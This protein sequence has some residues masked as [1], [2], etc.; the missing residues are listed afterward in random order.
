MSLKAKKVLA[1]KLYAKAL[2]TGEK[3]TGEV[4]L[5]AATQLIEND[6]TGYFHA[7][8][9]MNKLPVT[10]DEFIES[11]EF[12]GDV[13]TVWDTLRDDLRAYNPDVMTGLAP[14]FECVDGGATS[15]G[16]THKAMITQMYQLY[17]L[18]CFDDPVRL[19]P[20]LS[21]GTPIVMLFQSVQDRIT[22]RVIYQP[23]RKWFLSIPYV[24]RWVVH[25]KN[26]E[27][28]L[29]LDI[30]SGGIEV[31]PALANVTDIVGQAIIGGIL[32]EVNQMSIVEKSKQIAGPRGLGGHYDQAEMVHGELTRR[33]LGRFATKG[34]SVG[35]LSVLSS[36]RYKGD[37]LD[38]RQ[39][40]I[41]ANDEPNVIMRR[42]AQYEVQPDV[43]NDPDRFKVLVG[44]TDFS[45]MILPD[46]AKEGV[47]YM[48]GARILEVPE[49]YRPLFQ[50]DPEGALRDVCGIATDV[51]APY[52][53]K[54]HK[55]AE[56]FARA[57]K[58]GLV[59]FVHN[60]N[61][62]TSVDGMP[63][64]IPEA[65]PEDLTAERFIHIDLSRTG[66]RTGLA[67][68]KVVGSEAVTT[69]EGIVEIMPHIH[70]ELAV[71]IEPTP[72][73]PI[74]ISE[75]RRWVLALKNIYGFNIKRVT[76]DHVDSHESIMIFRASGISSDEVSIDRDTDPYD[77][78]RA[79]LYDDRIEIV[80]NDILKGELAN[81][82]ENKE[83]EK[84][85]HPPKGCFSGETRVAL[86]DGTCPTFEELTERY[87]PDDIFY[88]YSM[89]PEGVR[90]APARNPR[91][92]KQATELVE[93]QLDNF[94]VVRCTPDHLFMTLDGEWVQAGN[95]T[96]DISIMPLYRTRAH[97]GGWAGYERVWC[98]VREKRLLTHQLS[99]GCGGVTG[100]HVHHKDEV[101]HNNDPRNLEVMTHEEHTRKHSEE[102]WADKEDKM[103][104]G[105]K[106]YREDKDAQKQHA[107][108]MKKLWE[109]GSFRPRAKE[110]AIE[111][112]TSK[113]KARG[114][115]D[116]HYQRAKRAGKLP[117]RTS[118]AK[119]HRVLSVRWVTT[120]E[121]VYDL[122]VPDTENFA[123]ASGVF[124]HNSKDV[125]DAVAGCVYAATVSRKQR[126]KQ[127]VTTTKVANKINSS[128]RRRR[129]TRR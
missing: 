65:L 106:R 97:S 28:T 40:N 93:V 90:I 80:E 13:L 74:D 116:L 56:A 83:K 30:G 88:V 68:C 50:N 87:G 126:A 7:I 125:A 114:L 9:Q 34:V 51:I 102:R 77:T 25:D 113:S 128:T 96:P 42:R 57:M 111:G 11:P 46:N 82:E 123:L 27:S 5:N 23:F 55:I 73:E 103:R 19:F 3:R 16:K 98:P 119:N 8:G 85:D 39:A 108:R 47:D 75:I 60:Q 44:D 76:Y 86:A 32:D 37:F 79:A 12:L 49:R 104:A 45:T 78:L 43:V 15:T 112:C 61:V 84:I 18:T 4:F 29:R 70:V 52:I 54:R 20:N 105:H 22:R 110:C 101:K 129:A 24:K 10:I 2:A 118:K 120:D 64:V 36:T 63:A 122:T 62:L 26:R 121:P 107:E 71:S 31:A 17:L 69:S 95:L 124:V 33:R 35:T 67:M 38:R 1:E 14:I 6:N 81:L 94:Q 72:A 41:E 100:M 127:G 66:D 58:M 92:T 99:A 91:V 59:P 115:C 21:K 109:S 117:E 48:A 53:T 89:G